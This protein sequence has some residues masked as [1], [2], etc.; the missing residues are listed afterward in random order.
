MV[1][2]DRM[3]GASLYLDVAMSRLFLGLKH[4]G[5]Q[6]LGLGNQGSQSPEHGGVGRRW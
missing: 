4:D 5:R 2:Y 3:P 1:G 6:M